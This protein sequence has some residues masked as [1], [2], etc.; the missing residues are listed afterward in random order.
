MVRRGFRWLLTASSQCESPVT[1]GGD[2]RHPRRARPLRASRDRFVG[3]PHHHAGACHP[4]WARER[5]LPAQWHL[6]RHARGRAPALEVVNVGGRACLDGA[7]AAAR[8]RGSLSRRRPATGDRATRTPT[9]SD[10]PRC[11]GTRPVPAETGRAG[12][13]SSSC[14][15][16]SRI[17]LYQD[18]RNCAAR[19]SRCAS[20]RV[21]ALVCDATREQNS[22]PELVAV[23]GD[24]GAVP[25]SGS[26]WQRR[27]DRAGDTTHPPGL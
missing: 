27:N 1:H 6:G 9:A 3:P 12:V 7:H 10:G 17:R 8:S 14:P 25:T 15:L 23:E 18:L 5:T 13:S 4:T 26:R 11:A 22:L 21:D 24:S 2:G 16:P 20:M 19:A